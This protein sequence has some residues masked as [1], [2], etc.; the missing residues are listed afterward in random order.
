MM[1][2]AATLAMR[3]LERSG[4]DPALI[5]ALARLLADAYPIMGITTRDALAAYGEQQLPDV[6]RTDHTMVVIAQREGV[7]AGA[8][9]L[10]DYQMNVHGRDAFTGGVG[11][12]AVALTHKRQGI[13]RA[14]I[15]WYLDHYGA[16]DAAFG[17]L[18]P[19]RL[20]FYRALGFGYGTPVHRFRFAPATLRDHGARGTVRMLGESDLDALLACSERVRANTNGL[21]AKHRAVTARALGDPAMRYV[22]VEDAGTMRAFMQATVAGADAGLRNRDELIVRD[23]AY[24]DEGYLAALLG[25]LRNQR[26]QFARIVIESQDAALYLAA[27]D[28]RDGSDVAVAPPATHRVAE[29]GLGVMYRI[30]DVERALSYVPGTTAPF[31]LRID[32]DDPFQPLVGGARTFQFGP[33]R[34]PHRDDTASPD[35]TLTIGIHDLASVVVGSLRVRDLVRHRLASVEPAHALGTVDA[36][37]RADQP[38]YCT[39]RF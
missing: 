2:A 30:L 17:A 1:A 14:L 4:E 12:V 24:E 25:Y 13:A 26:D 20:D 18:H 32:A 38:P 33:R 16:R 31:A 37:F 29:T 6:L 5:A 7:L 10:Y 8:M 11:A 27:A 3:P 15:A 36:A 22:A 9:R 19:F 28:P 21:I 35:A 34:S 23:L 39:T